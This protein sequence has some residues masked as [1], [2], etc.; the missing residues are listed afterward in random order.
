MLVHELFPNAQMEKG[1][2]S[3]TFFSMNAMIIVVSASSH[4]QQNKMPR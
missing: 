4:V 3:H 2:L 1:V